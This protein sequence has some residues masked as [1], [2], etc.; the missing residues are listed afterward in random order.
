MGR[1]S[2]MMLMPMFDGSSMTKNQRRPFDSV[3]LNGCFQ[4]GKSHR[5]EDLERRDIDRERYWS[6]FLLKELL[7]ICKESC[8]AADD[9]WCGPR[10]KAKN[11]LMFLSVVRSSLLTGIEWSHQC[12][13]DLTDCLLV[14]FT[15]FGHRWWKQ[16]F[17][18]TGWVLR[19]NRINRAGF[20]ETVEKILVF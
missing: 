16:W 3:D 5:V 13:V 11:R 8:D 17:D 9:C 7:S 10:S 12:L 14:F 18:D 20:I 19:E 6:W 2:S 1:H 4:G 15:S